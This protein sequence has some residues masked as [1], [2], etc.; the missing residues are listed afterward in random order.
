MVDISELAM[1]TPET[2]GVSSVAVC[3]GR[4]TAGVNGD[5][6]SVVVSVGWASAAVIL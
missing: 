1:V 4:G 5:W 6:V 3:I 2:I